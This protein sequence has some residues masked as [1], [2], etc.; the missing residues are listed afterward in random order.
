MW[1]KLLADI[2]LKLGDKLIDYIDGLFRQW[3]KDMKD[4]KDVKNCMDI[5]D[6]I[7]RQKCLA[8]ELNSN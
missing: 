1:Q 3:L 4:K 6:P 7:E 2:I 5:K 8:N